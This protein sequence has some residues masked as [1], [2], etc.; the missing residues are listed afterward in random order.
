MTSQGPV[1]AVLPPQTAVGEDRTSL[2]AHGLLE[3]VCGELTR[4]P[5]LRVIS[6][7]SGA[8]VAHLS[9]REVG[10]RLG[11]THVLRSRVDNV[12]GRWRVTATL[13]ESS[14]GTQLWRETLVK[15]A[16]DP[17]GIQDELVGRISA[18]LAARL[19]QTTLAEARRKSPEKLAT[20]ELVLRGLALLRRGTPQADEEARQLF[21]RA[22]ELDPNHARAC[23]GLS[24]SY[25]NEWS[26][27][28]WDRFEEHGRLAYQH[29]HRALELDDRDA[30]LHVVIGRIHLYHRRFEQASWYF[31]R[32][33]ML[34]PNDAEN[35]IQL[36][37]CQAYLGH[38][39]T[40][41]KLAQR[42][43]RLNPYH[44]NQYYA[45]AA[46]SYFV[47]RQ[48]ETALEIGG[49]AGEPP[50]VDIP[51]YTAI[52]LAHL[53]RIDEARRHMAAYHAQFRTMIT[54]GREP[55]PEEPVNWLLE[56]NPFRRD[57]DVDMIIEGL[58][59]L[60]EPGAGPR[61][62]EPH[63]PV[64]DP[65]AHPATLSRQG[66][67]WVTEFGG[68]RAVLPDLKGIHDIRRLLER[69]GDE[70]HCLDLAG[71]G[72]EADGGDHVLDERA[73]HELYTRVTELQEA[74]SEAE[75]LNDLGRAERTREELDRVVEV[76]S[77]ALD[78]KGRT[79]RMGSLAERART[80]VTWR[81]RHATKKIGAVHEP[82][83][84]HLANSLRTGTFCSYQ[85][86]RPVHWKLTG[87][88]AARVPL[89]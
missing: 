60:G 39:D 74:L 23:A 3:D 61:H 47:D 45:Y 34:C 81:I 8:A 59:I 6:W 48:F 44:P 53:G 63:G 62:H 66:G 51:A 54:F 13:V 1:L 73:R 67:A 27:Q 89:A 5:A 26:C 31:D 16:E 57:E 64:P 49:K 15:P 78:L 70:I 46:L 9:D 2:L 40:A 84:R 28:F 88:P 76:L 69:P 50:I 36:S 22:L 24:L 29:A 20:Y 42:A 83:G 12:D 19:E 72:V 14:G 17:F 75:T 38:P 77:N 56:V 80:T 82:L 37:T 7:M 55:R 18:T 71:R 35:L 86:E 85:P 43:M 58:R 65:P 30:L 4:F 87:E 33:L 10:E 52:A 25:F 21:T 32:A 41:I 11:T 79:R 68:R